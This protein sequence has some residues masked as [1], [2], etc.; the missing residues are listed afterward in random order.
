MDEDV[1]KWFKEWFT[2]AEVCIS[3]VPVH[4]RGMA[5]KLIRYND[6]PCIM[7]PDA[8]VI[9]ENDDTCL[10]YPRPRVWSITYKDKAMEL[11]LEIIRTEY[12]NRYPFLYDGKNDQRSADVQ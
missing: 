2:V 8:C 1:L 7:G 6:V 10:Y 9:I 4:E 5:P 3:L 12:L 11:E